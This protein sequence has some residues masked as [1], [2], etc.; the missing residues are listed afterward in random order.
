MTQSQ[1]PLQSSAISQLL[2]LGFK[3]QLPPVPQRGIFK[4]AGIEKS[5]K[6]HLSLT[7]PG[8]IIYISIDIGTEGVVEK[9]QTGFQGQPPKQV[10]VYEVQ[11]HKEMSAQDAKN[12]WTKMQQIIDASLQVGQGTFVFDTWTEMY[13]LAR[14]SHF[15]GRLAQVMPGEYPIVYTDL[16]AKIRQIYDTNMNAVLITK[17]GTAFNEPGLEEKGF[18]DTDFLVQVNLRTQRV[19]VPQADGSTRSA[20]NFWVKDCRQNAFLNGM[21]FSSQ[22]DQGDMFNLEYLIHLIHNWTPQV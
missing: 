7:G 13:E 20:F 17:M 1:V 4:V 22:S 6:S 15:G 12:S 21:T 19:E 2:A 16:R 11:Y 8:P 3:D 14:L 10:L 5:G 18:K 9:F